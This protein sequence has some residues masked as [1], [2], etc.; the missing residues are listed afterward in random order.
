MTSVSPRFA[1]PLRFFTMGSA[2][3]AMLG[4]SLVML[5]WI[6]DIEALKSVFPDMATMKANTALAFLSLGT[7]LLLALIKING[8]NLY[9][10][11]YVLALLV[12]G[13]GLLTMIEYIFAWDAGIDN[14]LFVDRGTP[15]DQYPG[16]PSLGTAINFTLLGLA[17]WLKWRGV[18]RRVASLMA[19]IVFLISLLAVYG[20]VLAAP[21]LYSVIFYNSMAIHTALLFILLT[22]GCLA[23]DPM[24]W[25]VNIVFSEKIGGNL[26][27][28]LLPFALFGP[29]LLAMLFEYGV[30]RDL[31]H[32]EFGLALLSVSIAVTSAILI[33]FF[34]NRTNALDEIRRGKEALE[35]THAE[36]K[37]FADG[38]AKANARLEL[39]SGTDP[40]TELSNRRVFNARLGEE[41]ARSHRY[42]LPLSV[43]LLDVDNFKTYND[44]YGHPEGDE[45][46]KTIA[47]VLTQSVREVDCVARLGGEEFGIVMPETDMTR[48]RVT[49]ERVRVAVEQVAWSKR[50]VT[51]SIGIAA[52]SETIHDAK[53]LVGAADAALY[54]AKHKGRNCVVAAPE[55]GVMSVI[56]S[57]AMPDAISS[58]ESVIKS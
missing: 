12:F 15:L 8:V 6:L 16:R 51:V 13:F 30:K 26:S 5:G 44:A 40:L 17:F 4:A 58:Q 2:I 54:D 24:G 21:V 41:M 47:H 37:F 45:V 43:L 56:R 18:A 9:R 31:Y 53:S 1:T 25:L 23:F 46:L 7:S 35:K 11:H 32:S 57:A 42:K 28:W 27:R 14:I 50:V 52:I 20:Y 48:A 19:M 55:H 49:A 3:V 10:M 22:L 33:L 39:L 36:L 38:L 34:A 29:A